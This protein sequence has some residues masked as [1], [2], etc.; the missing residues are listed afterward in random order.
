M[1]RF[2]SLILCMTLVFTLFCGFSSS[3]P[4]VHA[5]A[6]RGKKVEQFVTSSFSSIFAVLYSDGTVAVGSEESLDSY[7]CVQHW[8]NVKKLWINC[9]ILIALHKN[10]TVSCA[11]PEWMEESGHF[12]TDHLKNVVDISFMEPNLFFVCLLKN[13]TLE[14]VS[15]EDD[16]PWWDMKNV[17]KLR[18]YLYYDIFAIMKNGTV[19]S[20]YENIPDDNFSSWRNIKELY[21]SAGKYYG[22]KN[23]GY[24]EIYNMDPQGG[25]QIPNEAKNLTGSQKIYTNNDPSGCV[26]GLTKNGKLLFSGGMYWYYNEYAKENGLALTDYSEFANITQLELDPNYMTNYT[27][28]LRKNGTVAALNRKIHRYVSQWEDVTKLALASDGGNY[29]LICGLTSKGTVHA[30]EIQGDGKITRYDDLFNGSVITDIYGNGDV[31]IAFRQNGS[32]VCAA[33]DNR[34]FTVQDPVG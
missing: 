8:K 21:F 22:V 31:V 28:A 32:L 13:G 18:S 6:A 29:T 5:L 24:V 34:Y 7:S 10:G 14:Y 9:D 19:K 12:E 20:L 2:L 15:H 30:L 4:S 25:T 17:S 11:Y 33:E 23:S 27:V 3:E 16:N 1:K 26:Y